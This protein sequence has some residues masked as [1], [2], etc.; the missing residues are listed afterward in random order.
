MVRIVSRPR[1]RPLDVGLGRDVQ[2]M[3]A[4]TKK[5]IVGDRFVGTRLGRGAVECVAAHGRT[6]LSSAPS[7]PVLPGRPILAPA[8]TRR[9][10]LRRNRAELLGSLY[11]FSEGLRL[12][13]QLPDHALAVHVLALGLPRRQLA[14][15]FLPSRPGRMVRRHSPLGGLT[16][17]DSGAGRCL[18]RRGLPGHVRPIRLHEPQGSAS[19]TL[20]YPLLALPFGPRCGRLLARGELPFTLFAGDTLALGLLPGTSLALAQFLR[21]GLAGGELTFGGLARHAL[22]LCLVPGEALALRQLASRLLQSCALEI[23]GLSRQALPL[24]LFTRQ[25]LAL[26]ELLLGGL[27]GRALPFGL[28]PGDTLPFGE[29]QGRLLESQ[30]LPFRFFTRQPLAFGKFGGQPFALGAL[31]LGLFQ[32]EPFAFGRFSNLTLAFGELLSGL[33]QGQALALGLLA[34]YPFLLLPFELQPFPFGALTLRLFAREPLP[35]LQV[36]RR[37]LQDLSLAFSRFPGE[38]LAFGRFTCEPLAFRLLGLQPFALGPFTVGLFTGDPLTLLQ[39]TRG[40]RQHL[41]LA[42][43]LFTGE[44]LTFRPLEHQPLALAEPFGLFVRGALG[45]GQRPFRSLSGSALAFGFLPCEPLASLL[46]PR[47]LLAIGAL[48]G[49]TQSALVFRHLT[50]GALVGLAR[51]LFVHGTIGGFAGQPLVFGTFQSILLD[52]HLLRLIPRDPLCLRT[53]FGR[54]LALRKPPLGRLA[55]VT[56]AFGLGEGRL[57]ASTQLGFPLVTILAL[58]TRLFDQA[59]LTSEKRPFRFRERG[60]LASAQLVFAFVSILAFCSR[61]LDEALLTGDDRALYVLPGG[62][63]TL[64]VRIAGGRRREVGFV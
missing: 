12:H 27:T 55:R 44:P 8:A 9:M 47:R 7:G 43:G 16:G 37:L 13:R 2:V 54:A 3:L 32:G 5:G 11:G 33:L 40:L 23:R 39:V 26:G 62:M 50:R 22:A 4:A 20:L 46:F 53:R 59:L 30:P 64:G 56:L 63:L 21:C 51:G 60:L 31:P 24:H 28:F 45:F 52:P 38:L 6:D 35:F 10:S 42:F 25:P 15:G 34:R 48:R 49:V 1:A 57:L 36:A 29:L 61:L 41:P 14:F 58:C 17:F 19:A 18:L